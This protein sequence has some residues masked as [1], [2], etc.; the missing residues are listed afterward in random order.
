MATDRPDDPAALLPEDSVLGLE[1]YLAMLAALGNQTRFEIVYRLVHGAPLSPTEL[2]ECLAIDDS[3]L[4]YHLNEL[5]D[6]GLLEKRT[7][8]ERGEEGLYTYYQP[9]VFGEVVLKEGI[10]ELLRGEGAFED[11]YSSS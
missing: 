6:V 11:M 5:L 1:D 2:E 4:H 9:T 3:T 8:T 7:R 10:E